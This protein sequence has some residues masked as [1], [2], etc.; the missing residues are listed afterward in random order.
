MNLRV[1]VT[2]N[3]SA[4]KKFLDGSYFSS[5]HKTSSDRS[6]THSRRFFGFSNLATAL[7]KG[8]FIV[9]RLGPLANQRSD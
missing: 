3:R 8:K 6:D 7:I 4:A 2:G 1:C 9:N 5:N